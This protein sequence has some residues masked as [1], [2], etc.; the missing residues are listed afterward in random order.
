[1]CAPAQAECLRPMQQRGPPARC[2]AGEAVRHWLSGAALMLR[3]MGS[4]GQEGERARG[5][6]GVRGED[7]C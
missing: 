1:M 6:E 5:L 2:E 3:L 7:D 4:Q